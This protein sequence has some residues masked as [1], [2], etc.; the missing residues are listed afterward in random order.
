MRKSIFRHFWNLEYVFGAIFV[1]LMVRA[2]YVISDNLPDADATSFLDPIFGRIDFLNIKDVSL[3]AIFAMKD[4][5]FSDDRVV[6]VNVNETAPTPDG[7]IALLL[8]K[9]NEW[10][11]KVVGIDVFFDD[12]HFER[13]TKERQFEI[14]ALKQALREVPNVVLANGFDE[15][16]LKPAI[17]VD[18]EIVRSVKNFGY[19]NLSAD[20]DDVIRRFYPYR[21]I[22]GKRWLF[23]PVKM[24]E[25]YNQQYIERLLQ[26]PEEKEIIYY[27][28]TFD[29]FYTYPI[30]DVLADNRYASNFKDAIVLVGLVNEKGLVNIGD[31]HKT[32][33]GRKTVVHESDGT[34]KIGMEGP[35]MAGVLIHANIINMLLKGEFIYPVPLWMDWLLVFVL[36]YFNI[37]LYRVLRTK[38]ATKLGLG[39]LIG[40][41]L[42]AETIIVFFLPIIVFFQLDIKISYHLM[43]TSVLLFIPANAW[44]IKLRY[45]LLHRRIDKKYADLPTHVIAPLKH[46]FVDDETFPSYMGSIHACQ[47]FLHYAF[48]IEAAKKIR[49]QSFDSDS[50]R[51]PQLA[52][53][54][55]FIPSIGQICQSNH[56]DDQWQHFFYSYLEGKKAQYLKDYEVKNL[57]LSTQYD[58]YNEHMYFEEWDIIVPHIH[59][60]FDRDLRDYHDYRIFHLIWEQSSAPH[61]ESIGVLTSTPKLNLNA[62]ANPKNGVYVSHRSHPD[63][64]IFASPLCEYVECKLHRQKELFVYAGL[65]H[66]QL[67][68]PPLPAYYGKTISCEPI[69]PETT[70]GLVKTH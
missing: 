1:I 29:Q 42:I 50:L 5:N 40:A 37:A 2:L 22:D 55:S 63:D 27:T 3:D 66:K 54:R 45:A 23:F 56:K 20:D 65:L 16:T 12:Q 59:R 28:G 13:F 44:A 25:L 6:V 52:E 4:K 32:P 17:R 33:M 35:D 39:F 19:V 62:F 26:L 14:T 8:H 34:T 18:S 64:L 51:F 70:I 68:N 11:A 31:T 53:W 47:Y 57:F 21:I 61:V 58:R 7:K 49:E 30:D 41:Y 36:S 10:G 24:L 69:L 43:A 38:P 48:A 9:A 15:N 67:V 60:M 46:A